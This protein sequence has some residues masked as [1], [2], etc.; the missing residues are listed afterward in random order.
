M[1]HRG[2]PPV[3]ATGARVLVLGSLPGA[4]SL[5][6]REYYA[7]PRNAFWPIFGAIVGA[8]PALPYSA[9]LARLEAAGIALWD[10][11]ASA[12]RDGSLDADIRNHQPNALAAFAATGS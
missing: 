2:F 1:S 11:C 6:R 5:R 3:A 7:Q 10:V 12:R 9:R 4:E 8:G